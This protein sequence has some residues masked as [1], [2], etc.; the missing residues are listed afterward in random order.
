MTLLPL[1]TLLLPVTL[2]FLVNFQVS[3]KIITVFSHQIF[4][5]GFVHAD[6]HPGN[7]L[8]RQSP[9]GGAEVVLLDHGLYNSLTEKYVPSVASRLHVIS[10][11]IASQ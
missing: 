4:H 10:L 6:P 1:T 8:I 3:K 11:R 2:P 5:S 7:V 9:L